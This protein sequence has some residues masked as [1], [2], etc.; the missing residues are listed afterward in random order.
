MKSTF[1]IASRFE[2]F[3]LLQVETSKLE[4]LKLELANLELN[5]KTGKL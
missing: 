5:K 2:F 4:D 3:F 1:I